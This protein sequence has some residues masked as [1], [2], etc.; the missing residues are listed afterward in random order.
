MSPSWSRASSDATGLA[1]A[2]PSGELRLPIVGVAGGL[3]RTM[4]TESLGPD[5]SLSIRPEALV[6]TLDARLRQAESCPGGKGASRTSP[7]A[8]RTR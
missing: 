3:T 6:I 8:P 2:R 7:H 5:A 1:V 4:L